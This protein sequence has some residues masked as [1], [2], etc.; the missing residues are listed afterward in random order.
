[1]LMQL[2]NQVGFEFDPLTGRAVK[3]D[4]A[5][6]GTTELWDLANL[7]VDVHPIHMHQAMFRVVERFAFNT[8]QYLLDRKGGRTPAFKNYIIGPAMPAP[9]E[10][11]G[12][13]DTVKANP[14]QL[15]RIAVKWLDYAGNYVY[16][17]HILEHEEHDMMRALTIK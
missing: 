8:A 17:C 11:N 2:I 13:K 14:D 9:A 4:T 10:E 3:P 1:M 16:H 15:T 12:W 5:T 7:T 6:L